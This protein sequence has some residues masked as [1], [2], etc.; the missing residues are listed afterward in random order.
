M[1]RFHINDLKSS[2]LLPQVNNLFLVCLNKLYGFH[3]KVTA[4]RGHFHDYLGMRFDY[5]V[6]GRVTIDMV[7]YM[8]K[9]V[10]EFPYDISKDVPY[11][12]S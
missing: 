12:R 1:M 3:G 2:H 8:T 9:L 11:P 4:T 7:D 6:P 10:D 5:S